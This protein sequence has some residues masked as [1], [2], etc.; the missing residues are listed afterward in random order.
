MGVDYDANYGIGY[1]VV[2]GDIPE[3]DM[4]D[5]LDEYLYNRIGDEFQYFHVGAGNYTGETDDAFIVVKDAF[6]DGL[7]LTLKKKMLDNE[8]IRLKLESVGDFGSVGG[9]RV[10]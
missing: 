1:Q 3:D 2:A 6:K 5:G 9:L 8:L 4:E 7:D 10:R